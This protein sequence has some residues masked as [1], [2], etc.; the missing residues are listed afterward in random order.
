MIGVTP[1]A[2]LSRVLPVL[3]GIPYFDRS[4]WTTVA[5]EYNPFSSTTRFQPMA[6]CSRTWSRGRSIEA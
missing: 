3:S 1:F 4:A 2:S 5:V 6:D